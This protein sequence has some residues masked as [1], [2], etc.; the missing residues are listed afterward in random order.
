M[1]TPRGGAKSSAAV[2]PEIDGFPG[3]QEKFTFFV[4]EKPWEH[5]KHMGI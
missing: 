4:R 5:G 2:H 3:N 1:E